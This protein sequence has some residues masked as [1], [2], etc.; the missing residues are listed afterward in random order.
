MI[1]NGCWILVL[2]D[3]LGHEL[4]APEQ[5]HQLDCVRER[6]LSVVGPLRV[7]SCPDARGFLA[8]VS[9]SSSPH[10]FRMGSTAQ[11]SMSLTTISFTCVFEGGLTD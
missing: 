1:I 6:V 9:V 2:L 10:S 11:Q 8:T 5:C 3:L 4:I 7:L